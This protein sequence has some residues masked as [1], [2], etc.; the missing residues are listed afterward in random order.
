MKYL[1]TALVVFISI[2]ISHAQGVAI[3]T[4]DSDPDASAILDV[5]STAQGVLFPR[6]T[7]AQRNAIASPIEGLMIYQTDN[8][9]GLRVYDGSNWS[10]LNPAVAFVKDIKAN[11]TDGGAAIAMTW[12]TRVFNTTQGNA[13]FISLNT[14]RFTLQ[15][16]EYIIEGSAPFRGLDRGKIK[17]RNI[18][19]ASDVQFGSVISGGNNISTVLSIVQASIEVSSSTTFEIQYWVNQAITSFDLGQASSTGDIEVYSQIKITK[20]AD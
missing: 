20:I 1:F 7:I 4:D 8:T 14:N 16:G 18:T 10:L 5:K 17:I 6:M 2:G 15:P 19:N 9:P 3:N 12:T 11:G 13:S